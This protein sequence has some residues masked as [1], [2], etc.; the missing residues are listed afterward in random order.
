[1]SDGQLT[2][3]FRLNLACE[4]GFQVVAITGSLADDGIIQTKDFL[5]QLLGQKPECRAIY[6]EGSESRPGPAKKTR[7]RAVRIDRVG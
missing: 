7:L 2:Q 5:C 4:N 3:T 6:P 1:M